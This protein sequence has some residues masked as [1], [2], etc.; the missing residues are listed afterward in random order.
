MQESAMMDRTRCDDDDGRLEM[1]VHSEMAMR[2][3]ENATGSAYEIE[4]NDRRGKE[5]T[6]TD[7]PTD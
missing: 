7:T 3:H 1:A 2:G 4:A 5:R 6:A